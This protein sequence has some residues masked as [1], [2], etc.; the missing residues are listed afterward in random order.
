[1]FD[2]P[3][4]PD[5]VQRTKRCL[6]CGLIVRVVRYWNPSPYNEEDG[7]MKPMVEPHMNKRHNPCEGSGEY[8]L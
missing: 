2:E 8:P 5:I 1:M 7:Y 4:K 6:Y 3:N